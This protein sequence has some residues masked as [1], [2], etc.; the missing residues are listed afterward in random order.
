VL[1]IGARSHHSLHVG[2]ANC[3]CKG[4]LAHS[5]LLSAA[6]AT[7]SR[8]VQAEVLKV[9]RKANFNEEQ[10]RKVACPRNYQL[11]AQCRARHEPHEMHGHT[12][13]E[14]HQ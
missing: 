5:Y 2:L 12:V 9:L 13:A 3:A 7:D 10:R 11:D 4:G 8:E 14:A 6:P 1:Y